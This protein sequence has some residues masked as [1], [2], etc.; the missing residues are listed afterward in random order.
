MIRSNSDAVSSLSNSS[1]KR[2][3]YAFSFASFSF[4]SFSSFPLP[5]SLCLSLLRPHGYEMPSELS[6]EY[7]KTGITGAL[8]ELAEEVEVLAEPGNGWLKLR[9]SDRGMDT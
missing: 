7:W 9:V 5:L 3:A 1:S 6:D 8:A 4:L 2:A